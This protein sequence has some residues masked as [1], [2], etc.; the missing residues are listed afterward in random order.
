MKIKR[1]ATLTLQIQATLK[2][3]RARQ[4]ELKPLAYRRVGR[5]LYVRDWD[6]VKEYTNNLALIYGLKRRDFVYIN[7][8]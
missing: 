6:R 3:L 2:A 8:F 5:E 4:R 7:S 1:S